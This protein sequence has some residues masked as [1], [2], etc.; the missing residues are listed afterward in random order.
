MPKVTFFT[1]KGITESFCPAG[2][3]LT[4]AAASAGVTIV[5]PCG[6]KG[7]CGNCRVVVEGEDSKPSA[8]EISFLRCD[9]RKGIRLACMTYVAGDCKAAVLSA[10]LKAETA[11]SAISSSTGLNKSKHF[12]AVADI[13]TTSVIID[14]YSL[15]EC[16]KAAHKVFMN[17]Q[18]NYGSDVV[19][20]LDYCINGDRKILTEIINSAID[21]AFESLN[22]NPEFVIVTGN[23]AMLHIA[24]GKDARGLANYPFEPETLFGEWIGDRYY[25]RCASAYI[26]GDVVASVLASRITES[27]AAAVLSDIGT[28][29]E[30]VLYNGT[31]LFACSS[32]A[33]PAFEGARISRGMPASDGAI[34]KV[35]IGGDG[36]VLCETVGNAKP[37]GF[38]GS[39]LISAVDE[40]YKNGYISHAG[41]ILAT[42]PEFGGVAITPSDIAELQLAKSAV[43]SGITSLAH[44]AGIGL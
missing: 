36:T 42:L 27:R 24:A 13:G 12:A 41:D 37:R 23:T 15:P 38:C 1:E 21:K 30:T 16:E 31:E 10:G 17:P 39:G 44:K 3:P 6:G 5:A 2:I 14:V 18:V 35:K 4:E 40:L 25:M 34:T 7:I 9:E 28:N 11:K 33:G 26:G 20:R 43:Y 29:N 32:A 8:A 22:V 19:T